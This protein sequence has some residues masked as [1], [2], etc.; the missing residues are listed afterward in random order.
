MNS[1]FTTIISGLC[2][3]ALGHTALAAE[4]WVPLV[5]GAAP[6]T[7]AELKF[8]AAASNESKSVVELS[9]A[10]FW[11]EDQ[12]GPDGVT[13]QRIRVPGLGHVG[14]IGA[15]DL[16]ALRATFGV[17]TQ[18]KILKLGK[19]TV[20]K[21]QDLKDYQVWPMGKPALDEDK[22]PAENPGAGDTKGSEEIFQKDNAIY[23][24]TL[25]WP[26]AD[27]SPAN[28]VAGKIAGIPGATCECYPI[29]FAPKTGNLSVATSVRYEF[30]HPGAIVKFDPIPQDLHRLA[31]NTFLNFADLVPHLP[32]ELK[33]YCSRYLII[34]PA[35]FVD[36]L[37]P[38]VALKQSQGFTVT[39]HA[40][41]GFQD[42]AAI[43]AIIAAWYDP[44]PVCENYCLIIGDTN[45]MALAHNS[46]K[47]TD[48]DDFY[49]SPLD[50]D[51]DEEVFVGR[52]S[53]DKGTDLTLQLDK[54]I[55]YQTTPVLLGHYD[56]ALLVAHEEGAPGKYQG[57]HE[58]V[59]T[60]SYSN[61]PDFLTRYGDANATNANVLDDIDDGVG[62]VC[63]RG[64]GSTFTWSDWNNANQDFHKNQVLELTN[65]VFPVVWSIACTNHNLATDGGGPIDCIG[66]AWLEVE[67]GAVASYA[68]T[69]TTFTTPNH[70]LDRRLF[71]AV[72]QRGLTVHAHALAW[73]EAKMMEAFPETLNA[74]A[75][76][77]LGDPSMRIRTRQPILF[78]PAIG[79]KVIKGKLS[80]LTI[81]V[82]GP[83]GPI[84]GAL[85]GAW[86][87][88]AAGKTELLTN[89]Y[90]DKTGTVK[91]D[92]LAPTLGEVK[93]V[94][95]D[96]IG[97][98]V[99]FAVPVVDAAGC[100]LAENQVYGLGKAG[101]SGVPKLVGLDLPV[102]GKVSSIEISNALPGATPLLVLG[103]NQVA[104]PFEQ[105]TLLVSPLLTVAL[106]KIGVNGKLVI[107]GAIPAD[108]NLCGA[109][110]YH[111]VYYVD[112]AA[113]GFHHLAMTNG[114]RRQF[115][116]Q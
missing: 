27:A 11:R 108:P 4:Q 92:L 51:L 13:Y 84:E 82:L 85:V 39:V 80:Q 53:V 110:L 68:A 88:D 55:A 31:L 59:R 65:K 101:A 35:E 111:Q 94:A 1:R 30:D 24:S 50:L 34:T 16:P 77:L 114:L 89:A 97:N 104:L 14:Q 86:K 28:P 105:G 17:V 44:L 83:Q 71:E 21:Q 8:D 7:P 46:A 41:N 102:I 43:Q 81:Q 33:I 64:H 42:A 26:P 109:N 98:A 32:P 9:I 25:P 87:P 112:P 58:S 70:E 107:A 75:Y 61:P 74:W 6:G 47:D 63:Y 57:A 73:A 15:P 79:G 5:A 49:G 56:R 72:Y 19:V 10:G 66:E 20:L 93:L 78:N 76:N 96:G 45:A 69:R 113:K 106:P 37:A 48:T 67:H 52:L 3:A 60:A 54:I 36:E 99:A 90:A 91:F 29:H 95:Q 40:V 116:Q 12:K 18:A 115:G 38:F 22:D 2:A 62:L 23:S 100:A 103:V